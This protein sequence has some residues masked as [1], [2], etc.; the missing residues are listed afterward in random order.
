MAKEVQ[1]DSGQKKSFEKKKDFSDSCQI[2]PDE[3]ENS[4]SQGSTSQRIGV[5]F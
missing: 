5:I 4:A 2:A 1:R 3:I